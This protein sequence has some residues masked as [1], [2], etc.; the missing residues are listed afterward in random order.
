M[1]RAFKDPWHGIA[2]GRPAIATEESAPGDPAGAT[3]WASWNGASNI[4][5]WRV[6]SG[7][8]GNTLSA[9]ATEPWENLETEIKV[10]G[11]LGPVIAVHALD[12]NGKVIGKSRAVP[13]GG[14][15]K[16]FQ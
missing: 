8:D 1:N 7:S 5:S 3:V 10:T 14:R 4:R 15:S 12:K 2:P 13:I 11:T 6:M 9:V 16:G